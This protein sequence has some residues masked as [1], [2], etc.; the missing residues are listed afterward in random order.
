M[1]KPI[2]LSD[3]YEK[4]FSED[5]INKMCNKNVW[6][7]FPFA[8]IAGHYSIEDAKKKMDKFAKLYKI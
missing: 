2:E 3:D 1:S 7:V 4:L 8:L 6:G 5:Y